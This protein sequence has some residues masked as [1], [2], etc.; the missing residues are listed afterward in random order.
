MEGNFI[1]ENCCSISA[2]VLIKDNRL[3]YKVCQC[4]SGDFK[5]TQT[6]GAA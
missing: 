4:S 6:N 1:L 3:K 5:R 2:R